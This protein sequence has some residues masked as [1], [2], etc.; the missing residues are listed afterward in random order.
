MLCEPAAFQAQVM[1]SPAAIVSTAGFWV[2]LWTLRKKML[3]TETSPTG[4]PPPP[5]PSGEV[6]PPH[7][8]TET[9]A[10]ATIDCMRRIVTTS[11]PVEMHQGVSAANAFHRVGLLPRGGGRDARWG[12]QH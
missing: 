4:G 11:L 5:P 8:A 9:R 10:A 1:L 3:P 2:P 7:A 6:A 12:A